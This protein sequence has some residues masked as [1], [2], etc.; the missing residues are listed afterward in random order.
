M[1]VLTSEK[2]KPLK[3]KKLRHA[4]YYD[5]TTIADK[6][7]SESK[8]GKTF[9]NLMELIARP[10]NIELA[11]RN[12]KRNHGSQTPGTDR[13]TID[14]IEKWSNEK[15]ISIIQSK[16][17]WYKSKPVRRKEIPKPNGKT[18]PLGIPCMLDRIVQQCILQILEPIC[19]AKFY[20][21]S[22]GF[23]P[24]RSAEQAIAQCEQMIN[25][26]KLHYVVDVDVKG[27]FDNVDHC[28]LRKQMWAM[29]IRDKKLLCVISEMLKAPILMPDGSMV[30][31]EKG[32][33]QGGVLSPLLANI[34]LNELDWWIASQWENMPTREQY[35]VRQ[36]ANG[37]EDKGSTYRALRKSNLKEMHIIRYA[38][39]FKIFCRKRS[40]TDKVFIA[41][42][43]WL[44]DRLKLDIS[45]EKS[46]VTN[47]KHSYTE[48]LG[49][50]LKVVRKS[51]KWIW[52]SHMADKAKKKVKAELVEQA[53][54]LQRPANNR[55]QYREINRFNSMVIG[56]H[57]YYRIATHISL[58]CNSI[59]RHVN[60]VLKNRLG[61]ALGKAGN[62]EKGYIKEHYGKSKQLRFCNGHPVIPVGFVRTKKPMQLKRSI[63]NYTPDGRANI[64]KTLEINMP[65]LHALMR[66]RNGNRSIEYMDNRISLYSAQ[67]GRC[68]VTGKELEV[69]EIHCHHKLP[70][71][72][73]GNDRY[74][75]L[76]IVHVLAHRLIHAVKEETIKQ[77]QSQLCLNHDMLTKLNK[78]REM[79]KLAP[80]GA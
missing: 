65:I 4:E 39:D 14:D 41:V 36:N 74:Q 78:L 6:L 55:E 45:E 42:K 52:R 80:I 43:K 5:M 22:N 2:Q 16:L 56:I 57:N 63:C 32:T 53:K 8:E 71:S 21:R 37:C 46:K 35:S 25:L 70:M 66:A 28:K 19:E 30:H 3:R 54:V 76:V 29:G 59:A 38:D 68:A 12:I 58:D 11:Y 13:L 62:L 69:G 47:L 24:N 34:V 61:K 60:V 48:F 40:D 23:R 9:T 50:K 51:G 17:S 20:Y 64:H 15:L 31:P 77:L 27:F 7:Y 18:R 33:P 73:G 72:L 67:K 79:A 49:F 26:Q 10:E 1:P 44:K 75:N